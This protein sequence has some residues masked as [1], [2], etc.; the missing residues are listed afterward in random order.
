MW[1]CFNN[2]VAFNQPIGSWDTSS[3]INMK[4]MFYGATSFDQDISQWDITNVT[5][6]NQFMG[7]ITL[8]TINYDALLIGWQQTLENAFPSGAGYT[9]TISISFG[10]SQFTIGGAGETAKNLLTTN[11]GWT[12]VDGGGI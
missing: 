10:N 1:Y 2:A 11:F 4:Y 12:I 5:D 3:V 8:S 6:F 9:P 7:L